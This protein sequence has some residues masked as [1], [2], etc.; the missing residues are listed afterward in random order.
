VLFWVG[1]VGVLLVVAVALSWGLR[2]YQDREHQP[3]TQRLRPA[4]PGRAPSPPSALP[5]AD[6]AHVLRRPIRGQ[7]GRVG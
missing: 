4:A 3:G 5:A 6:A 1:V 7:D 2:G